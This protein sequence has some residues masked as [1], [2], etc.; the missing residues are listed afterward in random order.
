VA[1]S[2]D[3]SA[4]WFFGGHLCSRFQANLAGLI[5]VVDRKI[6]DRCCTVAHQK[7][8]SPAW[9][10]RSLSHWNLH[11]N[12]CRLFLR[13]CYSAGLQVKGLIGRKSW[14]FVEN[15]L[16]RSPSRSPGSPISS[17]IDPSN[18]PCANPFSTS[19]EK[20]RFRSS[21]GI[22][23]KNMLHIVPMPQNFQYSD[24]H[25]SLRSGV[26][27]RSP[28]FVVYC[29]NIPCLPGTMKMSSKRRVNLRAQ[30]LVAYLINVPELPST[31]RLSPNGPLAI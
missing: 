19:L 9:K 15:P 18:L 1:S 17:S 6:P 24:I 28:T 26:N 14:A 21:L 30:T 13:V 2:L 25:H 4:P 11:F 5:R 22:R 23:K 12:S 29:I 10:P 20:S 7:S 31:L 16:F 27:L 8:Q 3:R